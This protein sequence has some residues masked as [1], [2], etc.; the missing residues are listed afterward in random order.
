CF[1][2]ER[3]SPKVT[4]IVQRMAAGSRRR[5]CK[6]YTSAVFSARR[7]RGPVQPAR[8]AIP[9]LPRSSSRRRSRRDH[10]D[11]AGHAASPARDA[12]FALRVA[13]ARGG[14]STSRC[15][16]VVVARRGDGN[17][18][19]QRP[20]MPIN[21]ILCAVD[22][23]PGS[24]QAMSTAVRLATAYDAELVLV[25]AWNL[26]A[27]VAGEYTYPADIPAQIINEA[28]RGLDAAV[29]EAT[30]LGANRVTAT[31]THGMPWQQIVDTA[32]ADPRF[33]LIVTG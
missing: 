14:R 26:P 19:A 9:R 2:V 32:K 23:S 21:K 27:A 12:G 17:P 4:E 15:M 31:L 18:L 22:F 5:A 11:R 7:P 24:Q 28:Q 16:A 33:D 25:H 13:R 8:S 29:A 20:T 6:S 3:T 30:K 10:R 1:Q